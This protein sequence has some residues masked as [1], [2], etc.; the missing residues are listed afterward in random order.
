MRAPIRFA[1]VK[2]NGVHVVR[3]DSSPNGD[4]SPGAASTPVSFTARSAKYRTAEVR[5]NTG[6]VTV[7]AIQ[8]TTAAPPSLSGAATIEATMLTAM[9]MSAARMIVP[10]TGQP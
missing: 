4:G 8:F 6:A 7:A 9:S 2:P 1:Y 10:N 5:A 3:G